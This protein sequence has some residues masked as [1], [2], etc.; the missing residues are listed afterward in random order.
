MPSLASPFAPQKEPKLVRAR[1]IPE[2][3]TYDSEIARFAQSLVQEGKIKASAIAASVNDLASIGTK[4][5]KKVEADG[6]GAEEVEPETKG[7][8]HDAGDL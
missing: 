1:Q 8:K 7:G 5:E 4:D 2:W 6:D 3:E